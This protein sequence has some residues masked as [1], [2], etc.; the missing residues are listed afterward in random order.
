[1]TMP[2][3]F[4]IEDMDSET[5]FMLVALG[6]SCVLLSLTLT[7]ALQELDLLRMAHNK[8]AGEFRLA[9]PPAPPNAQEARIY[10]LRGEGQ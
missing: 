4:S 7:W 8:L 1:M 5:K 9:H 2:P 10:I 6:V 3:T